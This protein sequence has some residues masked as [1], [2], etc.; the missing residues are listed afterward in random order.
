MGSQRR[1]VEQLDR[2]H[3]PY[4][5]SDKFLEL[6]DRLPSMGD[7]LSDAA[8]AY[9]QLG[10]GPVP[11]P[12]EMVKKARDKAVIELENT[13]REIDTHVIR[14]IAELGTLYK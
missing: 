14:L 4:Y 6:L 7:Q 5:E 10:E 9:L 8:Y 11:Y 3:V 13:L 1:L 12:L 2:L